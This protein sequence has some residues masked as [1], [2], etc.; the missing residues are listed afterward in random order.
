MKTID[1]NQRFFSQAPWVN[2]ATTVDRVI[3]G[4]PNRE[5]RH[6]LVTWISSLAACRAA[7]ERGERPRPFAPCA[8]VH[9]ELS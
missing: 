5:V 9:T 1:I 3:V 7:A 4:D 6:C 8:C 2:P